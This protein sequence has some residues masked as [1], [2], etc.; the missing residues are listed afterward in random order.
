MR[1]LALWH[2]PKEAGLSRGAQGLLVCHAALLPTSGLQD[3]QSLKGIKR[4]K[5]AV[6]AGGAAA[7]AAVLAAGSVESKENMQAS[8]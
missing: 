4:Q 7:A 8:A 5:Q 1:L 3:K 6:T 2:L